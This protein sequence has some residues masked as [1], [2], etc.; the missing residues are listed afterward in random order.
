MAVL[1]VVKKSTA[2]DV[3]VGT[4]EPKF[5]KATKLKLNSISE[6]PAKHHRIYYNCTLTACG[7]L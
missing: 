5:A 4:V 7:K 3:P 1:T 2:I 6:I